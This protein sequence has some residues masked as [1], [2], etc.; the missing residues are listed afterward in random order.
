MSRLDEREWLETDGLGGFASGT[1]SLV[2]TRRYHALFMAA[3]EPPGERFTLVNGVSA[4][5]SVDG[6]SFTLG[7]HRFADGEVHPASALLPSSFECS[8]WP[9]WRFEVPGAGVLVHEL[10]LVHESATC[11]MSWHW[12]SGSPGG[13]LRVRPF[14]SGRDVHALHHENPAIEMSPQA[15]AS[16]L[17]FDLYPGSAVPPVVVTST[18]RY[19][20]DPLWYRSFLYEEE[21]RRGF[22]C[23]ED[24]AAPGVFESDLSRLEAVLILS[25]EAGGAA[26]PLGISPT[27]W[28]RRLAERERARRAESQEAR[29]V[30]QY[31]VRRRGGASL[32]AGYPWFLDW[33][34]DTFISLRGLLLET[35]RYA[36]AKEILIEWA[37][38]CEGGLL[39]NRFPDRGQDP[40]YNSVDAALW[41]VIAASSFLEGEGAKESGITRGERETIESALE[42]ILDGLVR[43]TRHGIRVDDDGLL[44]A[45]EPGVQLTWMD[46]KIGD[47]V[48]TPRIGK[49]VE[50]QALW[51]NA[52]LAMSRQSR[53]RRALLAKGLKSFERRFWNERLGCL[54]DVVDV[55]H[56]AGT[57]DPSLRPNQ[58]FA[59]GGLPAALVSGRRAEAIVRRV[60]S[61]LWTPMGLRSLSPKDPRYVGRYEGGPVERDAA[62]HQG[63]V[64]LWL[65]GPFVEAWLRVNGP[66]AES[67]REA[68]RRFLEPLDQYRREVGFGHLPEIADGD[69]PHTARGCPFQAWS[70][71]ELIRIDRELTRSEVKRVARPTETKSQIRV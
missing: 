5:V 14:F 3:L 60:E 64:W 56:R 4:Q 28:R 42:A 31:L 70:L 49:P 54:Y 6:V 10:F 50:V 66:S 44:A 43:G 18:G 7:G 13:T 25:S 39:P 19:R 61:E 59:V 34:R 20:H 15:C 47:W 71:A 9:T 40:E 17:R 69:A 45:G 24:L 46:A 27:C 53:T 36:E 30:D 12:E 62:Y 68:R 65:I 41:Y 52:L 63:T 26:R 37:R 58:I 1:V 48:V 2:P 29:A 51:L 21:Q 33:G 55:D 22:D 35:G 16:G 57:V 67:A 23:L 11:V 8:P 38:A 32:I